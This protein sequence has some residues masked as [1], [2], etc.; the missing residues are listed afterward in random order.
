MIQYPYETQAIR[1]EQPLGPY[2]VI[3]LPARLLLDVAFSDVLSAEATGDPIRPYTLEG[4]QRE[5]QQKRLT[6]IGAYIDRTDSAFPNSIILAANIQ[7]GTGLIEEEAEDADGLAGLPGATDEEIAEAQ[8]AAHPSRRWQ[9]EE[10]PDGCHRMMIPTGDKLAAIIDGQHRLY[11]FTEI[12][13]LDRLDMELVCSVYLDLPKPFQAQL[14]ATVNSNQKRVDKSLT[15][16]LFGYNIEDEEAGYWA[17]DKLAVYLTRRLGADEESPLRGRIVIAP[18]KD[19]A[20]RD[21]Q[22]VAGWKISTAVVVDGI[23]RLVT[24]NPKADSN[25]MLTPMRR[26]RAALAD[27]DARRDRSPLR[28]AYIAGQDAVIYQ[29][30]LNYLIACSRVFWVNLQPTSFIVKTVGVQALFDILRKIAAEAYEG[31]DISVEYF[32]RILEP[33]QHLDFSQDVFRNASG[34]GRS[35]IR[36]AI[37]QETGLGPP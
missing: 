15:Y 35:V 16:E 27:D 28:A 37:E 5:P 30:I 33:A 32:Q 14:F 6:Q 12:E 36:R 17:P 34:S 13:L 10:R 22:S 3:K 11:G 31:R 23:L 21:A 18:R 25:A 24:S 29:L 7:P 2:Y 20:L 4:N 26:R 19:A 1:V 8:A 9:V